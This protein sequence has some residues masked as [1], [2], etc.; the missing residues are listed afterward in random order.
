MVMVSQWRREKR[1]VTERC[2]GQK[3]EQNDVII[4]APPLCQWISVKCMSLALLF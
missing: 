1:Y 3:A 4:R 2:E